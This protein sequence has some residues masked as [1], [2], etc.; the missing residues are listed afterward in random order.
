MKNYPK[1]ADDNAL[2]EPVVPVGVAPSAAIGLLPTLAVAIA[3]IAP[4][5]Q[6][7]AA[8]RTR[9][10]TRVANS[11][12]ANRLFETVRTNDGVWRELSTGVR[13][14]LQHADSATSTTI[15]ALEPGASWSLSELPALHSARGA[16]NLNAVH[17]CLVLSGE[18][19]LNGVKPEAQHLVADTL[20]ACDYQFIGTDAEWLNGTQLCTPS[21]A[22]LLWRTSVCG[23]SEFGTTAES[24]AVKGHDDGWEPLRQGVSIKPLHM[25]GERISML[26]RFEAGARVPAH[27]HSLGEE[28]LMV[29]GDLFL[30]DVLL[31]EREFQYAPAGSLHGGLFSDVGCLLFFSGAIDPDAVDPAVRGGH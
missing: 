17:E 18:V 4:P 9:L 24:H 23:A 1:T 25:V 6:M 21:G 8:L 16:N 14:R 28:C 20:S 2:L 5:V 22:Q 10:M 7:E 11:A 15:L 30:G 19:S 26:V 27:A 12:S 31:R 3:P 29:Q 13:A